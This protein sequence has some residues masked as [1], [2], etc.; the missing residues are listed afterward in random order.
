MLEG[1]WINSERKK[2]EIR[3]GCVVE[4]IFIS[5]ARDC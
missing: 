4:L 3:E 5:P 1:G 2:K